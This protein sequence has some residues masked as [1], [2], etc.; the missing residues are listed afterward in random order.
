MQ[1]RFTTLLAVAACVF[2]LAACGDDDGTNDATSTTT[3]APSLSG[4]DTITISGFSF[5]ALTV[6][7]GATVTVE[8]KDSVAHT[9]TAD[10]GEFD[11]G[12]IDGNESGSFTA[13][14]EAGR[15]PFHCS[16]HTSM[17]GT[18]TVT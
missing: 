10:G 11:A 18:L 12:T 14:S 16:I 4:D 8:N 3:R 2:A 13:P 9:V 17:K 1:R 5:N 15:Y 6:D 7:A